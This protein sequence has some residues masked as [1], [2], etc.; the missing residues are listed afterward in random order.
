MDNRDLKNI[1]VPEVENYF[2]S[3]WEAQVKLMEDYKEI[4]NWEVTWPLNLNVKSNQLLIKDMVARAVEELAEAYEALLEGNQANYFEE[5]ADATHFIVETL[6]LV[7]CKVPDLNRGLRKVVFDIT[8][9]DKPSGVPLD[10]IKAMSKVNYHSINDLNVDS[11]MWK[12]TYHLNL[13]RNA[14]RNKPWKQTEMMYNKEEFFSQLSQGFALFILGFLSHPGVGL[15]S[16]F[17][18]YYKKNII[19]RFRI[20]SKY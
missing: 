4:E 10:P 6:V 19:N 13:S 8:G 7:G 9:E 16:F 14:L 5:L 17:A 11:W 15:K 18:E 20:N 1:K 12:V 2:Q 3:I